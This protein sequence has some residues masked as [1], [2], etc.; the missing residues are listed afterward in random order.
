MTGTQRPAATR[1]AGTTAVQAPAVTT[2]VT[3]LP[4]YEA[5]IRAKA[6][7][8]AVGK[9]DRNNDQNFN[10]R[11]V[12]TVVNAVAA[13]LNKYGIILIPKAG[14]PTTKEVQTRRGGTMNHV[15]LPVT[16]QLT[17]IH[18]EHVDVDVI[19]EAFDAGDK[20]FSK[21]QSVAERVCLIQVLNLPTDEPDPDSTSEERAAPQSAGAAFDNAV[22]AA[23]HRGGNGQPNG[24]ARGGGNGQRDGQANGSGQQAPAR[25]A[26]KP[27]PPLDPADSWLLK[28][29]TFTTAEDA[30][31]AERELQA[32]YTANEI[33]QARANQVLYAI[34]QKAGTPTEAAA[35]PDPTPAPP[36]GTASRQSASAAGDTGEDAN[37]VTDFIASVASAQSAAAL[38]GLR[39]R[40]GP[41]IVDRLILADTATDLSAQILQRRRE[42]QG[43]GAPAQ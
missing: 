41:A 8:G 24:H 13:V 16:Y 36:P 32:A 5:I 30:Q 29:E 11:G 42:L 9:K 27:Q 34:R 25:Q 35:G 28:I 6:E 26:M 19:G 4:I 22:P 20:A 15:V 40:I 18:G 23:Q 1:P 7:V 17:D 39:T 43:T 2:E 33:D 12:D 10:F 31:L 21:A 3:P 14:T 37:W 38:D